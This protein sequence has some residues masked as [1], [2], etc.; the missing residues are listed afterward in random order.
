[1]R[2]ALLAFALLGMAT[3]DAS[4]HGPAGANAWR[5]LD[6]AESHVP[7]RGVR[8]VK[9]ELQRRVRIMAGHF[10]MGSSPTD[11]VRAAIL[12]KREVFAP[13]CDGQGIAQILR[14]EQYA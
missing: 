2:R 9:P 7:A 12:C 13:A 4:A 1:M 11:L 10:R 8:V 6:T 14:A 5:G 3:G